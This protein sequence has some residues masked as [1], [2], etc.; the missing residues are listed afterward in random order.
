MLGYTPLRLVEIQ[1][2][3]YKWRVADKKG[4]RTLSSGQRANQKK[5]NFKNVESLEFGL[6]RPSLSVGNKEEQTGT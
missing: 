3:L 6:A 4:R 1:S 5:K 2:K